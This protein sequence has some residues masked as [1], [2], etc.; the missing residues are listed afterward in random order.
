V[1]FN[2]ELPYFVDRVLPLLRQAGL[3]DDAV[4]TN[5]ISSTMS[6]ELAAS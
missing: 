5:A 2:E 3:R 1:N 4:Q 6:S